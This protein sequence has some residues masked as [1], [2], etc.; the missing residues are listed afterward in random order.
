MKAKRIVALWIALACLVGCFG[1]GSVD[2][3]E[4]SGETALRL[5]RTE[6]AM[7]GFEIGVFNSISQTLNDSKAYTLERIK[8]RLAGE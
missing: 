6:V 5:V 1:C 3:P 2:A 7:D 8:S 4:E